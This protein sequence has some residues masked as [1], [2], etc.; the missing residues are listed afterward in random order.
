[1]QRTLNFM[2][3]ALLGAVLLAAEA[4]H[5]Q[6]AATG[7][8]GP[9][10]SARPG[11]TFRPEVDATASLWDRVRGAGNERVRQAYPDLINEVAMEAKFAWKDRDRPHYA[12]QIHDIFLKYIDPLPTDDVRQSVLEAA[13]ERGIPD[14]AGRQ[15]IL[16][17]YARH[18]EHDDAL[19]IQDVRTRLVRGA[20]SQDRRPAQEVPFTTFAGFGR[21][22]STHGFSLRSFNST[23]PKGPKPKSGNPRPRR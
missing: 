11:R 20:T 17:L 13:A 1:M 9:S 10:P 18:K 12:S 22:P 15:N 7:H 2:G 5:A 3:T 6:C 19:A 8:C 14:E 23:A 21:S 4:A 16:N